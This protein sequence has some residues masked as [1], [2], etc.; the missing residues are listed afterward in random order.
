MIVCVI[1]S[2]SDP[3]KYVPLGGKREE[4][5]TR[6]QFHTSKLVNVLSDKS[7]ASSKLN[8]FKCYNLKGKYP[9]V[10]KIWPHYK[11]F[12]N[13]FNFNKKFVE[14]DLLVQKVLHCNEQ[15]LQRAGKSLWRFCC[16][17]GY[18]ILFIY[19]SSLTKR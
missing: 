1:L 3:L 6:F 15:C 16:Q 8:S 13:Y 4:G 14:M 12:Q 9:L 18:L 10:H 17:E 11:L 19:K 5:I 2:N 7:G